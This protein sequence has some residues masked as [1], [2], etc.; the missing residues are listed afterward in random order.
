[1]LPTVN[2]PEQFEAL[3]CLVG[4]GEAV[5]PLVTRLLDDV[6]PEFQHSLC[7]DVELA[8]PAKGPVA[9]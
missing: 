9:G 8:R 4:E 3:A 7:G 5:H 1:M 2:L 6:V